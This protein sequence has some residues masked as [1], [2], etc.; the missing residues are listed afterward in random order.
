M[1]LSFI[2]T[3]GLL[4]KAKEHGLILLIRPYTDRMLQTDFRVS[5]ALV[6]FALRQAGE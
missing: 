3:L 1:E 6:E 2:G 4:L 5:R